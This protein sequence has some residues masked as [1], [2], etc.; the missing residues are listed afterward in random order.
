MHLGVLCLTS[1]FESRPSGAAGYL[2]DAKVLNYFT[3]N[4][5]NFFRSMVFYSISFVSPKLVLYSGIT[6]GTGHNKIHSVTMASAWT[7]DEVIMASMN[8]STQM[9]ACKSLFTST[10]KM[11][12]FLSN[13]FAPA[14]KFLRIRLA[15]TTT[16]L[17]AWTCSKKGSLRL[18]KASI[19]WWVRWA[20]KL[21][22][23]KIGN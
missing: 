17:S 11:G 13:S 6:M 5:S 10:T 16:R 19:H 23:P 22:K 1:L 7:L 8:L 9:E 2:R 21:A 15:C 14:A 4:P 18:H 12:S 3:S 20:S